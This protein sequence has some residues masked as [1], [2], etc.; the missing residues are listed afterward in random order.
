M[1]WRA[2]LQHFLP[3]LFAAA[4]ASASPHEWAVAYQNVENH[5]IRATFN[6]WNP[7]VEQPGEF[8]LSQLWLL[9]GTETL[10]AGWQVSRNLYGDD[11]T[12]LFIYSSAA[13]CYNLNCRGFVQTNRD[14]VIGGPLSCTSVEGGPQ[15]EITL[16]Y[17][18]SD[19]GDWWLKVD[20][21]AVGYYPAA[22]FTPT[23]LGRGATTVEVGGEVVNQ[24]A[25][26]Q[27]TTTWM[28]S[29]RAPAAGYV[30]NVQYVDLGNSYRDA[31]ALTLETPGSYQIAA[32][33][34]YLF[35]GGPGRA[36]SQTTLRAAS[37]S[38]TTVTTPS[39]VDVA[40]TID[41]TMDDDVIIGAELGNAAILTDDRRAALSPGSNAVVRSF[42]VPPALPPGS[43]ALSATIWR[44]LNRNGVNDRNDQLL[45]TV[46]Y[47]NAVTV[48]APR[49]RASR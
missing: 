4:T 6:V 46:T 48:A 19:Y 1:A 17:S 11:R 15:C 41:A 8:S 34:G 47:P 42:A 40:F 39:A 24:S 27:H 49:L 36:L 18:R 10:E 14:L 26:G 28:G 38:A 12:H 13:G 32:N 31:T 7:Y 30:R 44:D 45:G 23:G 5:G 9:G 43:Y 37:T 21:V 20:G 33:A 25:N 22:L 29:G 2:M 3:I 35:F 16:E